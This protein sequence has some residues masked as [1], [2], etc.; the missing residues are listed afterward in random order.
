LDKVAVLASGG[1]DSAV[2]LADLA[3]NANV[4]PVYVEAGL[5]WEAHERRALQAYLEALD[6]SNVQPLTLLE[7]PVRRLYGDHWSTTGEGVPGADE[8]DEAVY[9]PGRNVLLIG[10]TAVWCAIHD[11]GSIAIGSLD[12]NPFPDAT[13]RFF[14]DYGRLLSDALDHDLRVVAPYRGRHKHE[15]IAAFPQLPLE[16]TLTCMSPRDSSAG[17]PTVQPGSRLTVHCGACNKCFERQQAFAKAGVPD[18][19][20]YAS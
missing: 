16:L 3:K 9:L 14:E 19:T 13:P 8:P 5:A 11:V 15:I 17:V 1:L 12:D 18:R 6:S 20:H 7:M 10:V 2:L 4:Y